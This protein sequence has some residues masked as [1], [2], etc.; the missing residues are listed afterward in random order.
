MIFRDGWVTEGREYLP[1]GAWCFSKNFSSTKFGLEAVCLYGEGFYQVPS[2]IRFRLE[3]R[4]SARH[5]IVPFGDKGG[6]IA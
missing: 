5:F 6:L 2:F 4:V 1:P 3:T